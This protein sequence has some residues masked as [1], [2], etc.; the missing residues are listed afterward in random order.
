MGR[1]GKKY[2]DEM[3]L[4][5]M[6]GMRDRMHTH[7]MPAAAVREWRAI[8]AEFVRPLVEAGERALARLGR[9]S[10]RGNG[11]SGDVEVRFEH[12]L[13]LLQQAAFGSSG[14]GGQREVA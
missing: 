4:V 6:A 10:R 13:E 2:G 12:R 11:C 3:T 1:D 8:Q 9:R 14:R 5:E 7:G